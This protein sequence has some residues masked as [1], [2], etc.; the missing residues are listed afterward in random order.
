[1]P[2]LTAYTN[3]NFS[4][5]A[6]L[7]EE[8]SEIVASALGKPIGYVAVNLIYNPAMAF[9]GNSA[10]KGVMAQ[11]ISVGVGGK[12][13]L[14]TALTDFFTERLQ[15]KDTKFIDIALIASPAS[16]AACGGRSFG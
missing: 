14:I 8:A 2:Y 5:G 10:N 13:E 15:I 6:A 16:L 11:L 7:A 9:G 1:M 4:N 3:V 12:D